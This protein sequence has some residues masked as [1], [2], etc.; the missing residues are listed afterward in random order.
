M[1]EDRHRYAPSGKDGKANSKPIER[2]DNART[3]FLRAQARAALRPL[4]VSPT[5][6]VLCTSGA[7]E[8][9][10]YAATSHCMRASPGLGRSAIGI[11]AQTALASQTGA[12]CAGYLTFRCICPPF[13][14]AAELPRRLCGCCASLTCRRWG[15]SVPSAPQRLGR[16]VPARRGG[17]AAPCSAR[18]TG[19]GLKK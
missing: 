14:L 12:G 1:L 18:E 15:G 5:T 3:H 19:F 6:F 4:L 11:A 2:R 9:G 8:R 10:S 16:D 17:Q 7:R 13:L